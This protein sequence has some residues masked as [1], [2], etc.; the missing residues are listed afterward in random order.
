MSEQEKKGPGRPKTDEEVLATAKAMYE[1]T[2]GMSLNEVAEKVGVGNSVLKKYASE[3]GWRKNRSF[4]N[5]EPAAQAVADQYKARVEDAGPEITAEDKAKI[6]EEITQKLAVDA[7]AQMLDRHRREWAAP[8]AMS[9][10]A[11]RMRDKNSLQAFER[12]K[13]AKITAETL[14]IVQDGE[15]KAWG[16]DVGELPPGSVVVIERDATYPEKPLKDVTPK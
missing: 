2:R 16:L 3:Q 11:V 14:K 13:L 9:A 12:A 8:R 6:T 4:A 7:R 10:E 5:M 1:S 15:R